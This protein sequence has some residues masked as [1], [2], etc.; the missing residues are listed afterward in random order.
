M[1]DLAQL[2]VSP[3]CTTWEASDSVCRRSEHAEVRHVWFATTNRTVATISG[4]LAGAFHVSV[5]LLVCKTCVC[6]NR[7]DTSA[8]RPIH[9]GQLH[10]R[11][12]YF[13]FDIDTLPHFFLADLSY[14]SESIALMRKICDS[15]SANLS[16]LKK[17]T[18]STFFVLLHFRILVVFMTGRNCFGRNCRYM[19]LCFVFIIYLFTSLQVKDIVVTLQTHPVTE[20]KGKCLIYCKQCEISKTPMSPDL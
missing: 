20:N 6:L 18:K 11:K 2:F 13:F 9:G 16:A 19:Q 15:R 14:V 12:K 10:E 7:K 1:R 5:A 4:L 3:R 17:Q 8:T